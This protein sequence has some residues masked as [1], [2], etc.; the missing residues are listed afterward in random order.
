MNQ[1]PRPSV[2]AA[3]RPRRRLRPDEGPALVT[4]EAHRPLAQDA[5]LR[6]I[7]ID[8][9]LQL[10]HMGATGLKPASATV[11]PS[12]THDVVDV[13]PLALPADDVD[14]I[15]ELAY[16]YAVSGAYEVARVLYAGLVALRPDDARHRLGLGVALDRLGRTAAAEAEYRRAARLE[17][18]DPRAR[19]NLAELCL[20][21]GEWSSARALLNEARRCPA[22]PQSPLAT[23]IAAMLRIIYS[24][25]TRSARCVG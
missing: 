17:P 5:L 2:R 4:P 9:S 1:R 21:R 22:A 11:E 23:K 7:P 18:T 14:N 8:E 19:V 15:A 13:R 10:T 20:A 12:S 6:P 3:P 25:T 24:R 16:E